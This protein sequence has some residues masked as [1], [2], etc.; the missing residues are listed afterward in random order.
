VSG[1][2]LPEEEDADLASFPPSRAKLGEQLKPAILSVLFL[3]LLTGGVFPLILFLIARPLL[4]EQSRGSLLQCGDAVVGSKLIGQDFTRPEYF[5]PRPAVTA[6]GYDP[7]SSG[8]TNLAPDNPKWRNGAADFRGIR[9]L[10]SEYRERNGLAP[11]TPIPMDAVTR[12]GS[13]LDPHISP[14]NAELQ[15]P[16]VARARGLSE[17]VVRRLVALHTQGPQLGF[18]GSARVSV[19]ELNLDLD[20]SARRGA[21]A[22]SVEF[23]CT[24]STGANTLSSW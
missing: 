13:G 17:Q 3:T 2:D 12:S 6:S 8:G 18:L 15:I 24:T 19:L 5:Q 10:A 7:T 1:S 21:Q 14:T 20:R 11:D 23:V 9:Q 16:R 22:A 4:P